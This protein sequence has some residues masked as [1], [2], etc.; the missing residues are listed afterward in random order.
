M[1]NWTAIRDFLAVAEAGSL[2]G[3]A[4][5]LRISQ[6]TLGRRIQALEEDLGVELFVRTPQGLE[7]TDS[8]HVIRNHA[9]HMQDDAF[10]I[11]RLIKGREEGLSG[12]VTISVI[13]GMGSYWLTKELKAFHEIYPNIQ[14][15]LKTEI[16]VADLLRREADIA[17]R[18]FE[19]EQMDLIAKKAG[20]IGL[21]LFASKDYLAKHGTPTTPE[22]LNEHNLVMPTPDEAYWIEKHWNEHKLPWGNIVYRSNNMLATLNAMSCGYGIGIHSCLLAGF[23]DNLVQVLPDVYC[24]DMEF[25]LVTHAE[26]RRSAKIRAVFDFLSDLFQ[27]NKKLLSGEIKMHDIAAE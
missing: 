22:A 5:Q 18:M 16:S 7:L 19:P 8:A 9:Q 13:E 12:S 11:E 26:L 17:I 2:S 10:A 23:D 14:I 1:M 6:P 4:R 27:K 15:V 21:G 25:W 20:R 24:H 3:A